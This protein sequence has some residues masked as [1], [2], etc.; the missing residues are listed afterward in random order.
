MWPNAS[1]DSISL[2]FELAAIN[3]VK[4]VFPDSQLFGCLFHLMKN[5]RKKLCD[6]SLIKTY[7]TESDFATFCRCI[8]A[9]AF[10]P[11]NDL[12]DGLA[13]LEE[14]LPETTHEVL[15]WFEDTYIGMLFKTTK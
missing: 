5:L 2:D 11:I 8:V 13:C 9:L 15:N 10:V 6:L 14:N 4:E 1:F 3:G 7:N 12:N